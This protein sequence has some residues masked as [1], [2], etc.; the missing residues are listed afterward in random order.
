MAF[1]YL[2]GKRKRLSKGKVL[3]GGI[4]TLPKPF[5]P[6]HIHSLMPVLMLPSYGRRLQICPMLFLPIQSTMCPFGSTG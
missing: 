2:I 6:K 3:W 1:L 4:A 5:L